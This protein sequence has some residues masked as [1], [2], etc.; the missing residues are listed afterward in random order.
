MNNAN[1]PAL[2]PAQ[3]N[4]QLRTLDIN[5]LTYIEK[6]REFDGKKE[7]L[8]TFITNVDDIIPTLM[9][10]NEQAQRM[11]MNIV[12][13]KLTG[14]ARR[15]MEVHPHLTLWTDIKAMLNT[16]FGGFATVDQLYQELRAAQYKG[17]TMDFYNHIQHKLA[18]LNQKCGQENRLDEVDRNIQTGLKTFITRLPI[19]MRTVLCALK[20]QSMEEALHEL[21]SAGFLNN[22][23]KK[24]KPQ[25]S[26]QQQHWQPKIMQPHYQQQQHWQPTIMQPHYQQQQQHW[27][28]KIMQP[29][30]QQ[31]QHWQPRIMQPHYQQQQHWQPRIVQ[32]NFQQHGS[33][34]PY[35]KP[36]QP[37]IRQQ[38]PTSY[39]QKHESMDVDASQQSK[40]QTHHQEQKSCLWKSL[41][42]IFL[43]ISPVVAQKLEVVDL[44]KG[45]GYAMIQLNDKMLIYDYI[46]ILHIFNTT[47]YMDFLNE[48][49]EE[50]SHIND[51]FLSHEIEHIHLRLKS[52]IP[53]QARNRRGLINLFGTGLKYLYGTMDNN[54]REEIERQ[55]QNLEKNEHNIIT[56]TNNQIHINT[57]FDNQ[58]ANLT[59]LYND[60]TKLLIKSM[61]NVKSIKD[62]TA[63][64][65][66]VYRLKYQIDHMGKLLDKVRDL[67][68][69]S[70][71]NILTR[72]ILSD[73]E[74]RIYNITIDKMKEIKMNLA[75]Y[76]N[77]I[78]F[79]LK[80]PQYNPKIFQEVY[81]QP[82][83]NKEKMQINIAEKLYITKDNKI[84]YDV[85]ET[86]NLREVE[87]DCISNLFNYKLMKCHYIQNTKPKVVEIGLNIIIAINTNQIV[88]HT[89]NKYPLKLSG[90]H[91][92]IIENCKVKLDKWYNKVMFQNMLIIPNPYR[93]IHMIN[94]SYDSL[95]E[96]QYHHIKNTE[97]ISEI[98]FEQK[99]TN[100]TVIV[101]TA[102]IILIIALYLYI[103]YRSST[104]KVTMPFPSAPLE[105]GKES[106]SGGVITQT[107]MPFQ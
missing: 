105:H 12:K 39:Q 40:R 42:A 64:A 83:P 43:M 3:N 70:K 32:P 33:Q 104:V 36:Q 27:Q 100:Y 14:N 80:V 99:V 47:K 8:T 63:K 56:Q 90:N 98:K 13:S 62:N 84:Y 91:M 50:V 87:D 46:K 93:D 58:L 24:D 22:E 45:N 71:L 20:P 76:K 97:F 61:S 60:Q 78:V 49:G 41:L 74:I 59:K 101:L 94:D 11:C 55:L 65:D 54:D 102:V 21:S 81:I 23:K 19:H 16:N 69:A 6:L 88:N 86:P 9:L 44:N 57:Q 48:L 15:A 92:L 82:I 34:Q 10:Y 31:Q 95:E 18:I 89:C 79:V 52:I 66:K 30:Y 107:K 73:E 77:N 7:D 26:P 38:P 106:S 51:S 68:L 5:P 29:H 53:H 67:I 75:L 37:Q 4:I 1:Q 25:P 17:D 96:I 35:Y 2:N 103:K 28:P 85:N 72:D